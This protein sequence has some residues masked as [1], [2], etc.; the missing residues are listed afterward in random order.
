MSWKFTDF[1][2]W[3]FVFAF[4]SFLAVHHAYMKSPTP[5]REIASWSKPAPAPWYDASYKL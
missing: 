2:T 4:C 1:C 3:A 5:S